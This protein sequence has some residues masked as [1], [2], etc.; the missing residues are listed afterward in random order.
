[1]IGKGNERKKKIQEKEREMGKR[2][3]EIEKRQEKYGEK[4]YTN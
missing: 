1:M 2:K 3:I 4:G